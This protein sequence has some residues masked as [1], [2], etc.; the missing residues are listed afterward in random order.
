MLTLRGGGRLHIPRKEHGGGEECGL[1]LVNT[2]F[3]PGKG[4][5]GEGRWH[6]DRVSF[7][8]VPEGNGMCRGHRRWEEMW[9]HLSLGWRMEGVGA[10]TNGEL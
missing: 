8:C 2:G 5:G 1:C 3:L 4:D 7:V 6:L 9:L 10:G